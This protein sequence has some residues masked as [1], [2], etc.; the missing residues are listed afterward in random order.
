[1]L[2]YEAEAQLRCFESDNAHEGVRAFLE[3]RDPRFTGH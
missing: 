1:M 2:R 3:K